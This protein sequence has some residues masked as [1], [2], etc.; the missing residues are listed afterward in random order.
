VFRVSVYPGALC[1]NVFD[2]SLPAPLPL[3]FFHGYTSDSRSDGRFG[4]GWTSPYDLVLARGAR[5]YALH[6]DGEEVAVLTPGGEPAGGF[7]L[8][9][10]PGAWAVDDKAKA[11][12]YHF[13][14]GAAAG[15][16]MPLAC[17][18]DRYDN[19]ITFE[20]GAVTDSAGRRMETVFNGKLLE[21]VTLSAHAG[22]KVQHLLLE[23]R[24]DREGRLV[25][26]TDA[27]GGVHRY[28]YDGRYLV[29][30]TNPLG[31]G[32]GA[33]YDGA[34]CVVRVWEQQ[35]RRSR[36][37]RYDAERRTTWVTDSLGHT[38]LFRFNEQGAL[39]ERV[40]P[41]GGVTRSLLNDAGAVTA[42]IDPTGQIREFLHSR[43]DGKV[44]TTNG[45]GA[46]TAVELDPGGRAVA[47]QDV[48]GHQW[49]YERDDKGKVVA[50]ATPAGH[51]W[52]LGMNKRGELT[53]ITDP[54]G[55]VETF[56]PSPD[57]SAEIRRDAAGRETTRHYD[58]LGRIV[59][60][61]SRANDA[62]LTV[63][64]EGPREIVRH[65]DG[66]TRTTEYDVMGNPVRRDDENG[67][68]WRFAFDV[69]GRR[70]TRTDPL[71]S[72][73]GY[74]YDPEGRALAVV[75]ENGE[76]FEN[77][78]NELG[79]VVRQVRF[80]GVCRAFEYDGAGRI[81]GMTDGNGRHVRITP[82]GVGRPRVR[83]FPDGTR[84]EDAYD[85]AG[86]Q[87]MAG[88]FHGALERQYDPDGRLAAESYEGVDVQY[89]YG[90]RDVPLAVR[91][92]ARVVR[93]DY[94]KAGRLRSAAEGDGTAEW[95]LDCAYADATG[96]VDVRYNTGLRWQQTFDARRRLTRQQVT[97][98]SGA[99]LYEERFSYDAAGNLVARTRGGTQTPE[100]TEY[101]HNERDELVEVTRAG[102]AVARYAYD[103]AGNRVS[104]LQ[105]RATI[106]KGNRL[107]RSPRAT[108][109]YDGEGRPVARLEGPAQRRTDFEYDALGRLR[110][111][112][113]AADQGRQPVRFRYDGLFRRRAKSSGDDVRTTVWSKDVPFQEEQSDG[114][115]VRYVFHP[116]DQ[117][118]L[119][120]AV[121]TEWHAVITDHH[122]EAAALIR[123][124]DEQVVWRADPLGFVSQAD[125]AD[126]TSQPFPFVIRGL[127]QQHDPETGLVYQ[128]AR[129]YDPREGRF[130][131]PDPIG[132]FGGWNVYRYC[133]NQPLKL[134]DPLGLLCLAECDALHD[135]I[136]AQAQR[137]E[138]R[139][140]E[141]NTPHQILPWDG[142][143][144]YGQP[145]GAAGGVAADGTAI[146]GG[147]A[148]MGSVE[149]HIDAFDQEQMGG[150]GNGGLQN[151][152][153]RYY[154]GGCAQHHA[155]DPAR[156]QGMEHAGEWSMRRPELPAYPAPPPN[157]AGRL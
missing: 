78:Y 32:Y 73:I 13:R 27:R 15:G 113:P 8:R 56:D 68:T 60:I 10:A 94:D 117:R 55:G 50:F 143:P 20:L 130:A 43:E 5:G 140:N 107:M 74:E 91:C 28:G 39:L 79:W 58:A 110:E 152:I 149:S 123:M 22:R 157:I 137:V 103:R 19:R 104:D 67:R 75:N 151:R 116:I 65:S 97:S 120:V 26:S 125:D 63:R 84:V 155:T 128:R 81:V 18:T 76:R 138:T 145:W 62:R 108:F 93:Y 80:D 66:A 30:Y 1:L 77:T 40:D 136:T 156:R 142:A 96:A 111:V 146:A 135:Q 31:G 139:W 23:C 133:L 148:S 119:A 124:A 98:G 89:E 86:R 153:Q 61:H 105:G 21:R 42:V 72:T 12:T 109:E 6:R 102:R 101:E 82:N 49:K 114:T 64:Y 47:I 131:S 88:D 45:D 11:L 92:G 99:V 69:Y 4:A 24:Y 132:I 118:P 121:G 36:Y 37:F 154:E 83:T 52:K 134:T 34:G 2:F 106:G 95:A 38:T 144:P 25:Q 3:W 16:V 115:L 100:R 44:C 150:G 9:A 7:A 57:G 141:M 87:V 53:R 17:V 51:A 85:P 122:G 54:G 129:Y 48:C 127:G 147:T 90:W 35:G 33:A 46:T 126:S 70:L 14:E 29:S 41:A 112:R 71:G 59:A